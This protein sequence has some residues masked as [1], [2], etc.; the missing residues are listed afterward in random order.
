MEGMV[1][2]KVCSQMVVVD[3]RRFFDPQAARRRC[4]RWQD[5]VVNHVDSH[6]TVLASLV[7]HPSFPEVFRNAVATLIRRLP[8]GDMAD[9]SRPRHPVTMVTFCKMGR[10]RSVAM[11]WFLAH[12]A[13][14]LAD[15]HL[16]RVRGMQL[17]R[18]MQGE[19]VRP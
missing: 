14:V 12:H 6:D 19:D 13:R 15:R 16:Q 5:T 9:R 4:L 17:R 8:G 1:L 3:C 2:D 10:Q 18:V 11:A 7:N